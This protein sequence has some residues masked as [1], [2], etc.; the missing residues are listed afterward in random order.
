MMG[1]DDDQ[2]SNN[3]TCAHPQSLTGK[4][5]DTAGS[6]YDHRNKHTHGNTN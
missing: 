1:S 3:K 6:F 5:P 4:Q 2:L